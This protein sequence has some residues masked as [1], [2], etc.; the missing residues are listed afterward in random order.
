[1]DAIA[2]V[3]G[4]QNRRGHLTGSPAG[5]EP[6]SLGA[7][8]SWL[9]IHEAN[10]LLQHGIGGNAASSTREAAGGNLVPNAGALCRF[11][12]DEIPIVRGS[13]LAALK[14]ENEKIGK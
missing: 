11:P 3:E 4:G 14:G 7:E 13:A 10:P 1:V 5:R 6:R 12:G 9:A 2:K 8:C